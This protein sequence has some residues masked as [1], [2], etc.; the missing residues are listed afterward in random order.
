MDMQNSKTE[1]WAKGKDQEVGVNQRALIDKVLARYSGEYTVFREL[2]QNSDDAE[3][4]TAEIHFSTK[5]YQS[6]AGIQSQRSRVDSVS[7]FTL[8]SF[9]RRPLVQ[10]M[11]RNDGMPFRDQDWDRLRKI[12]KGNPDDK[13]IGAFGVG[14]YSLFSVT[15]EPF[16]R[17]GTQ[18]MCFYWKDKGDQLFTKRGDLTSPPEYAPSG[19]PWTSFEMPLRQPSSLPGPPM[20]IARFLATSLTFMTNLRDVSVF[21]DNNRLIRIQKDIGQINPLSVPIDL[22]PKS[23]LGFMEVKTVHS[24]KIPISA[25]ISRCAFDNTVG[26]D[27]SQ[28]K[29]AGPLFKEFFSSIFTQFSPGRISSTTEE[30]QDLTRDVKGDPLE[31]LY[32]SATLFSYS[33][34]VDVTLDE[35]MITEMERA[36]KKK[37]PSTCAFSLLHHGHD[38]HERTLQEDVFEGLR[39]D[40][41]GSGSARVFIGHATSQ[42]TGIGGHVSARFIPTVERE[43]IDLVDRSVSQW[44]KELLYI[45]GFLSRFIYDMQMSKIRDSWEQSI[46][47][48][49]A[50]SSKVAANIITPSLEDQ[51]VRAMRYFSFYP[52]TPSP[53]VGT[54]MERSFFSCAHD[55]SIS[56][57]STAGVRPADQ[58]W[59]Y[60]EK[61][62]AFMKNLPMLSKSIVSGAPAMI[63]VLRNRGM[64]PSI[65]AGDVLERLAGTVLSEEEMVKCLEW[66]ASLDEAEL[67]PGDE[68]LGPSDFLKVATFKSSKLQGGG[69]ERIISLASIKFFLSSKSIIPLTSPLPSNTLPPSIGENLTIDVL[70]S[71]FAWSD[72]RVVEWVEYLVSPS[73]LGSLPQDQKITCSAV[74]AE[75]VLRIVGKSWPTL[76]DD[77]KDR[78][79]A[80]L[81]DKTV[82]PTNNGM[83]V[84]RRSYFPEGNPFPDLS[85][86]QM[87][88]QTPVTGALDTLLALLGVARHVEIRIVIE[89]MIDTGSWD[90]LDLIAYLVAKRSLISPIEFGN[91][92]RKA[93]FP[94][95]Q[96][97]GTAQIRTLLSELYEPLDEIRE[98]GLPVL[99]WGDHVWDPQSR[100]ASLLFELGLK[101]RSDMPEQQM[102]KS[103]ATTEGSSTSFS[104]IDISIDFGKLDAHDLAGYLVSNQTSI[105]EAEF[106]VL[107]QKVLFPRAQVPG[108]QEDK[109]TPSELY[110]PLDVFRQ[111]GLPV[112][113]W[114][115][116][117]WDPWSREASIL[118]ELG[119]KRY[120]D[121]RTMMELMVKS[122]ETIR[123]IA[124]KF[125]W[126]NFNKHYAFISKTDELRQSAFIPAVKPDG[127]R[128][129]SKPDDASYLN[130][131]YMRGGANEMVLV[132][133]EIR[134]VAECALS[135]AQH[136][137]IQSVMETIL[138]KPPNTAQIAQGYFE[139]LA[140]RVLDFSP[141]DYQVLRDARIIP[142]S[143]PNDDFK[144][145]DEH[146]WVMVKPA[147]C[148]F[149]TDA[150]T[151]F[152]DLY[153][154][155]FVTVDF[156]CAANNFLKACGIK[157][158]PDIEDITAIILQNPKKFLNAVGGAKGYIE[159]LRRIAASYRDFPSGLIS[160]MR[161]SPFLFG[162]CRTMRMS[163]PSSTDV[164]D[165]DG[166]EFDLTFDLLKPEEVA[167]VDD[168]DSYL[169]FADSLYVAPEED[170]LETFYFSLGSRR[171]TTLIKDECHAYDIDSFE[172]NIASKAR[173]LIIE[174][175][176]LFLHESNMQVRVNPAWIAVKDN[177]AVRVCARLSLN[178]T[179]NFHNNFVFKRQDVS[180]EAI[181]AQWRGR[182][183]LVLLLKQHNELDVYE[184]A[185]SLCK[186]LLI[187]PR[188]KDSL[189]L[190]TILS[191]DLESLRRRG[192]N[193]DRILNQP[194]LTIAEEIQ[195]VENVKLPSQGHEN[196]RL[197]RQ[198]LSPITAI[199]TINP[200]Q[201]V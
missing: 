99:D 151:T 43:S 200:P 133:S 123:N 126:N 128:F 28:S 16:V 62:Q 91:L 15:D 67:R 116:Y 130:Y 175:L 54:E 75:S 122:D 195:L 170:V 125:F 42:S 27:T 29:R 84:P 86:V 198:S 179:L 101:R 26:K 48:E 30:P 40:V 189:L 32:S 52:T 132:D 191:T 92:R 76:P 114:G 180:A 51:S 45:G 183:R 171:L 39:T 104:K 124:R 158:E 196:R 108:A 98:L 127:T 95:R 185:N 10:W 138:G 106:A 96:I 129:M 71:A 181:I 176:P 24:Q 56:V 199:I 146:F 37:P 140:N 18:W 184:M 161:A 33:A 177:F 1:L 81:E 150:K 79:I 190:M 73:A 120:P 11:F 50:H 113:D 19:S 145:R 90:T 115:V 139:Y 89:R 165:A 87:P 187:N 2:L 169:L 102:E 188:P 135:V 105:P 163:S 137:P 61:V 154:K 65:N 166:S 3:S 142:T 100:E 136:P 60:N 41:N 44:N 94:Q 197:E 36:T 49:L 160:R 12:A 193:V 68:Q 131:I 119:L 134:D 182:I 6:S 186:A 64:L 74:F 46:T 25:E 143:S 22:I 97:P 167:I 82:T 47:S 63:K 121:F 194:K 4:T 21:I 7:S 69:D 172:S 70:R 111:L 144:S 157:D 35:K 173:N 9:Q 23:T 107:R 141:H 14:F 58:V 156:G 112:L 53:L 152:S 13:K 174:R 88:S 178:R 55:K 85:T 118:F 153:S 103:N 149:G 192:Y 8:R 162:Q 66:W 31:V 109:S 38:D 77:D 57:L 110:E 147:E 83:K 80:V 72:L 78:L 117:V 155:L 34:Q 164:D 20:D 17:S 159:Q 168:T 5:A 93:V 59:F 201:T 148:V